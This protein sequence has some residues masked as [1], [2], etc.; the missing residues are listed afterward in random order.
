MFEQRSIRGRPGKRDINNPDHYGA[1]L[2]LHGRRCD[3]RRRDYLPGPV[4]SFRQAQVLFRQE[5]KYKFF[6]R[7]RLDHIDGPVEFRPIATRGADP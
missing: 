2:L 5:G 1:A 6:R 4:S 3:E 7:D